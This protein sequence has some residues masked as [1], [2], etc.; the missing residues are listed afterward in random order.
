MH[1][2]LNSVCHSSRRL[3]RGRT[4]DSCQLTVEPDTNQ[5]ASGAITI[6]IGADI[7]EFEWK[8]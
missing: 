6:M 8:V 5:L 7:P 4:G 1:C 3:H 2:Q